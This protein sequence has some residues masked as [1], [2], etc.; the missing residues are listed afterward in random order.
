MC[1]STEAA[2]V[3]VTEQLLDRSQVLTRF[4]QVRREAV[5]QRVARHPLRDADRLR[6]PLD[7]LAVDLAMHVMPPPHPCLR[8]DRGLPCW[9]QPKTLRGGSVLDGAKRSP[10]GE[11]ARRGSR[12]KTIRSSPP[13]GRI[14]VPT[15]REYELP[16]ALR[17]DLFP[18]APAPFRSVR[19]ALHKDSPAAL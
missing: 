7:R 14:S 18:T 17:P 16:P 2:N 19:Q 11:A 15:L 4:E 5:P 9:K 6:R 3:L 12:V 13:R 10:Q 1:G 8:I